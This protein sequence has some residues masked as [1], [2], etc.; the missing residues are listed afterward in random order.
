MDDKQYKA[1]LLIVIVGFVSFCFYL[2]PPW[3]FSMV[4][5]VVKREADDPSLNQSTA[6]PMYSAAEESKGTDGVEPKVLSPYSRWKRDEK[7]RTSF[8]KSR[9][10]ADDK[11]A[12]AVAER[13]AEA[14]AATKEL[15]EE[16]CVLLEQ[17]LGFK[18][19]SSFAV[20]GFAQRGPHH[21]WLKSIEALKKSTPIGPTHPIPFS[22]RCAVGDLHMLGLAYLQGES[23]YTR[24]IIREIKEAIDYDEYLAAKRKN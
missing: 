9:A 21:G 1:Y 14:A 6:K 23:D 8:F 16:T 20:N 22:V 4:L 12:A 18:N 13:K 2:S 3:P 7:A 15:K 17:L 11:V 24:F 10:A 19:S 5:G